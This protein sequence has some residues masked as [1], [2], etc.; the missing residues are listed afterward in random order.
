MKVGVLGSGEVGKRLAGGF[1][2]RVMRCQS[3]RAT[4]RSLRTLPPS[5]VAKSAQPRLKSRRALLN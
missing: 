2:S 4:P 1:A 5:T 3:V